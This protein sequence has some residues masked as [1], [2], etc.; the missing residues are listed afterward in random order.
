MVGADY[1]IELSEQLILSGLSKLCNQHPVFSLSIKR[2]DM[3]VDYMDSWIP[4]ESLIEVYADEN[5]E[6]EEI[7]KEYQTYKFD[8]DSLNQPLWKLIL[9]KNTNSLILLTDHT[10]MLTGD[11]SSDST[12]SKELSLISFP[13]KSP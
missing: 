13:L 11:I 10:F 9:V 7:M 1:P 6:V 5:D 4:T 3:T 2:K 12:S 8:Y